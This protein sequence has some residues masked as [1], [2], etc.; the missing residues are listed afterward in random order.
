MKKRDH[1]IKFFVL[2]LLSLGM[3]VQAQNNA[4]HSV[5]AEHSWYRLAV[6]HE[7]VYKIDRTS[8]VEMGIDAEGVNP[9][10]IRVFGAPAG[11]LPEK[12]SDPRPD[13]LEELAIFVEGAEDG[14][15]DAEDYVLFYGQEPTC[16]KLNSSLTQKYERQRN[17][18][19]DTTYY[20]LCVDS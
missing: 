5:L 4:Y 9:D 20:Y 6:A 12:N 17:Y 2:L 10:Q 19:S 1:Y 3:Q 18:Y 8:F 15:F 13:D 11:I 14:R 7:G 16:W